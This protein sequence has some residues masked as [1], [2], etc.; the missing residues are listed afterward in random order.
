[1]HFGEY[2]RTH[3]PT[4]RVYLPTA[5]YDEMGEWA[6]PA[7]AQ[8]QYNDVKRA[9]EARGELDRARAFFRGGIWQNFLAKYPEANFMHKKMVQV[10]DKLA[11][12]EKKLGT[13]G[14]RSG[15]TRGASG[16][17]VPSRMPVSMGRALDHARRELYRAQC[18]C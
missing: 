5:S 14:E 3:P 2:L 7:D 12:A 18:N 13:D 11:A 6:L 17:A 10:S 15:A 9:L 1:M 4:G 16:E 8:L